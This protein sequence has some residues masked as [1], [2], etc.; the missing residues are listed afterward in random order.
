MLN[1]REVYYYSILNTYLEDVKGLIVDVGASGFNHATAKLIRNGMRSL[2]IEPHPELYKNLL[3]EYKE[4]SDVSIINAAVSDTEGF[5][6]FYCHENPGLSSLEKNNFFLS[7][8]RVENTKIHVF[9]L[10]TILTMQCAPKMFELLKVDTEGFDYRI[11]R[12]M[13]EESSYRPHLIM[14]E[15]QHPGADEFIGLMKRFDYDVIS[16]YP[17]YGNIIYRKWNLT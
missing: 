1:D 11:L 12:C 5:A 17:Q 3:Y 2:L 10:Q 14:H 7:E 15:I 13:F 8:T 16:D 6:S 9:K 4:R